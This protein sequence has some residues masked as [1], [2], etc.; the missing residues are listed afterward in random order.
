[1][2]STTSGSSSSESF[3]STI[4]D[5]HASARTSASPWPDRTASRNADTACRKI[6]TAST[7][8]NEI[9]STDV[10]DPSSP[11][12][13][14]DTETS[15]LTD[16]SDPSDASS[17]TSSDN[18]SGAS[19]SEPSAPG[20]PSD[21]A[22]VTAARTRNV[23]PSSLRVPLPPDTALTSNAYSPGT[24]NWLRPDHPA[25]AN[26]FFLESRTISPSAPTDRPDRL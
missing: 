20:P 21:M 1:M 7:D 3:R 13:E 6:R 15:N 18:A 17:D 9:E 8:S 14:Y 22:S 12:T 19:S 10:S 24:L 26:L 5:M 2:A 11:M 16:A 25:G 4:A 23:L